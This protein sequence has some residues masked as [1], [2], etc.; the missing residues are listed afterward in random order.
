MHLS[1]SAIKS[2]ICPVC[3]SQII[4]VDDNFECK[5]IKCKKKFPLIDGVPILINENNSIF[6]ISNFLDRKSTTILLQSSGNFKRLL[7]RLMPK[8]GKN[9]NGEKNFTRFLDILLSNAKPAKVLVIGGESL[10]DGMDALIKS[11]EIELIE[12]D[13]SLTSR[14]MLICDGH[15]IPFLDNTFDGVVIQAV[16]EHVVDPYRCVEEIYRVLKD[17]SLVYS[18]TPFMQQ[19]H[20]GCYDFTRFTHLGHRRLF[21]RFEEIESGAVCGPGMALAWSYQYFLLSFFKSNI[22]KK[23]VIYFTNF[24]S[25]FLKYFDYY[26]INREGV[27]D[28]ASGYYFLGKKSDLILSDKDLIKGYRGSQ[29]R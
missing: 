6:S 25:F 19:V 26:L 8:I 23:L 24:T 16:L 22:M 1:K 27:F 3:K 21:R 10:G 18:E 12:T 14:T 2:L 29:K 15:D 5:E 20:M 11:E 7:S 28:S 4:K 17:E 13:V 9:I